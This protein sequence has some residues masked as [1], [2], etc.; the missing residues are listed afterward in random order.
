MSCF[1]IGV[2]MFTTKE[3]QMDIMKLSETRK[4]IPNV[5]IDTITD[6]VVSYLLYKLEMYAFCGLYIVQLACQL[7]IRRY[8]YDYNDIKR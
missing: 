2:V 4:L 7:K 1:N 6:L 5:Y 8:Y 3:Y